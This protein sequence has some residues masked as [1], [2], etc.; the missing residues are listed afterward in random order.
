MK[1]PDEIARECLGSADDD[2]ELFMA[3]A[4]ALTAERARAEKAEAEA[5]RKAWHAAEVRG[6][7]I[8]DETIEECAGHFD[9]MPGS[10]WTGLEVAS[11]IRALKEPTDGQA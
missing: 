7:R 5:D 11:E 3:I 6:D 2:R 4:A 9:Q 10:E 8:R 1:T